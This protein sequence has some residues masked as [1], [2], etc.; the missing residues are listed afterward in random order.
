[1]TLNII[2]LI[3]LSTFM[4]A[5]WNLLARYNHAERS[6]YQK[7]LAIATFVG[8][9]PAVLSELKFPSMNAQAWICVS[10][11]G[12]FAGLYLFFLARAYEDSDFTIVYPVARALPVL[13]VAF[14]DIVRGRTL[15]FL[16]WVGIFLVAAGCVIVP[17]KSLRDIRISNYYNRAGLWMFLAA[18]GTVGYTILDK[19]GSESIPLGPIS[20]AKYCYFYFAISYLPYL[21]LLRFFKPRKISNTT[22]EWVLAAIATMFG[23]SAYWL[24]I[25]A[26]QLSPY[27]GYIVAF[28]Q[29]SIIIGAVIAFII[30]KEGGIKVRLVGALSI[31]LGLLLIGLWG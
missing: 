9:I 30:Y 25:W 12:I 23:F 5:G 19:I 1:M 20:A 17:Q 18:L 7:M 2:G 6:F 10:G 14:G 21:L 3:F 16:G 22:N 24:V 29:F 4:H 28:R 11:S 13:F 27:A 31:S 8:F 26:F 15:T